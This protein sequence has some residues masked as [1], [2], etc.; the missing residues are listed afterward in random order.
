MPLA[1]TSRDVFGAD[2]FCQSCRICEEAC[3]PEALFPE[4]QTVRGVQKW[5]VD[6]D[7]CLPFFNQ[8]Q[9]CGICIA[10][11]PWSRPGVGPNLAAKLERRA[12][13]LLASAG[14]GKT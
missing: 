5:Y 13:R 12:E 7:K 3:P 6:F 1:P 11:C 8:T 9:G 10:V 4:K 14:E 2:A